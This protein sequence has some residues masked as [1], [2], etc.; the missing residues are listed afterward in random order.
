MRPWG[1]QRV[2][3]LLKARKWQRQ[4]SNPGLTGWRKKGGRSPFHS[5][6][7]GQVCHEGSRKSFS[8]SC[9]KP[10]LV[11]TSWATE[12]STTARPMTALSPPQ[13]SPVGRGATG[14]WGASLRKLWAPESEGKRSRERILM[15]KACVDDPTL[16]LYNT[17]NTC[18]IF[19]DPLRIFLLQLQGTALE[20]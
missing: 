13:W 16:I 8:L 18:N 9:K 10:T 3:S 12:T 6:V 2:N 1:F 17:E 19:Y 5:W 7:L 15:Q 11:V 4:M 20:K 14:I